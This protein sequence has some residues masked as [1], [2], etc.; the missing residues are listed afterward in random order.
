MGVHRVSGVLIEDTA[1]W[2][3]K[4]Y[5]A[6]KRTLR[7]TDCKLRHAKV[8]KVTEIHQKQGKILL[9]A[10]RGRTAHWQLDLGFSIS[11]TAL[12]VIYNYLSSTPSYDGTPRKQ[13][14]PN[15]EKYLYLNSIQTTEHDEERTQWEFDFFLYD[16]IFFSCLIALASTSRTILT[17]YGE[18]EQK[19]NLF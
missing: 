1:A 16:L 15:T 14:L 8:W 3:E 17:R 19:L 10:F 2:R 11:R 13:I 9:D 5:M 12:Y 18:S 7:P 4:C 6:V